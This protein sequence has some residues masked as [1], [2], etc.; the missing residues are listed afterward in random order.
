MVLIPPFINAIF[1]IEPSNALKW[2]I[3]SILI[4]SLWLTAY[5]VIIIFVLELFGVGL[6]VVFADHIALFD[7]AETLIFLLVTGGIV[8]I[9]AVLLQNT[10]T[11]LQKSQK[12][13]ERA[14]KAKSEFLANMS[15]E[16]RTPLNSVLGFSQILRSKYFSNLIQCGF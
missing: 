6:L 11:Q 4:G 7:V 15:H 13:A 2:L 14:N 16:L 10:F 1:G 3:V 9:S 5:K 12:D 8:L